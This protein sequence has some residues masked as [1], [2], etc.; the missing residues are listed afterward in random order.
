[1]IYGNSI[2]GV[3]QDIPEKTS[4]SVFYAT[5]KN[6]TAT[7]CVRLTFTD[8]NFSP[9]TWDWNTDSLCFIS[10]N[11]DWHLDDVRRFAYSEKEIMKKGLSEVVEWWIESR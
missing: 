1:M 6:D 9:S 3:P 11:G 2:R 10:E 7:V 8:E 5:T 4:F